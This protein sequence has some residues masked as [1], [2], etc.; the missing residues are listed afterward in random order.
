M[1]CFPPDQQESSSALVMIGPA[2]RKVV[3]DVISSSE[4][5]RT[6]R[7]L[8][9]SNA[10]KV[11]LISDPATDKASAALDVHTGK[12]FLCL[13]SFIIVIHHKNVI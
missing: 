7:G 11:L 10:L 12:G 4:D 2:V 13:W 5:R 3:S 9:L 8:E 6:Y 1:G